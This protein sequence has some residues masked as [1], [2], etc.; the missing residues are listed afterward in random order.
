MGADKN[1]G[2]RG[3]SLFHEASK[4]VSL[5]EARRYIG[6]RENVTDGLVRGHLRGGGTFTTLRSS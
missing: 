6:V 2:G 5:E 3:S 4:S 1:P